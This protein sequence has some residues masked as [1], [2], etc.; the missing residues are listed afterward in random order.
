MNGNL[1]NLMSE[2]SYFA[3]GSLL[4]K[5]VDFGYLAEMLSYYDETSLIVLAN[6]CFKLPHLLSDSCLLNHLKNMIRSVPL[7]PLQRLDAVKVILRGVKPENL[8]LISDLLWDIQS[9][10]FDSFN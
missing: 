9:E 6:F 1:V 7:S 3:S 8:E 4:Q 5:F 10:F 2:L